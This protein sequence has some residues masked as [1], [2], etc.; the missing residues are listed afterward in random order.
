MRLSRTSR[1]LFVLAVVAV[2]AYAVLELPRRRDETP[3]R[4]FAP[5]AAP[6]DALQID[7]PG[8]RVRAEVRGSRWE[9][10]EPVADLADYSRIATLIAE[11]ERA[12]IARHLGPADDLAPYGLAPPAAVVAFE[13]HGATLA[14]LELGSLTV[15]KA[16]AY[17]RRDDGDVILIP[18]GVLGAATHPSDAYR[19][20]H[21]ARFDV[22]A[23]DAFTVRRDREP[24]VRWQR[25][26]GW[27]TTVDSDTVP[28]DSVQVPMYLRR[29]SG[30]RVR[31]F[32][33][34]ADT[35]G[36][37]AALAG[38]VTL[39]RANGPALTMRFAARPDSVY[40]CRLDGAARV[41]VVQGDVPGALN[42]TAAALRDRRLLH[43]SPLRAQRIRFVAADTSAVLVRA[44]G[45]WA[46]PNPGLGSVN[47]RAAADFV[48]ALRT[49]QYRRV[50]ADGQQRAEPAAFTLAVMAGGDT[51]LD[52]LRG[53]QD[54]STQDWIVTSRSTGLTAELANQ[55][56]AGVW[57]SLRRIRTATR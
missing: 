52:E 56:W 45:A 14:R 8:Q 11:V 34:P 46:L 2:A 51:L 1:V 32:V 19:D 20:S 47:A 48:R 12:E 29:F 57:Q 3:D 50:L 35:A 38:S 37:F 9:L 4:L 16:Y 36:A 54:P 25:G 17:A 43:F 26:N 5:F 6:I 33:P 13:S 44:G 30:M 10:I 7:R 15:D 53:R 27:F 28:G 24:P 21:L 31:S 41:V 22:A 55:R 49:L 18:P 40:W 23:I 39:H 42:A